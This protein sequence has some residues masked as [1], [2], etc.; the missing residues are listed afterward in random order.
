MVE[1]KKTMASVRKIWVGQRRAVVMKSCWEWAWSG[2][3]I[4]K[5]VLDIVILFRR[6]G[7]FL[8]I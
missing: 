6:A 4:V 8:R 2:L 1:K 7:C 3:W 5:A